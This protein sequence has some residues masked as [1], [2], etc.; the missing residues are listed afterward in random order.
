MGATLTTMSNTSFAESL[1]VSVTLTSNGA[2]TT[3]DGGNIK[4]LDLKLQLYA[5][6]GVVRIWVVAADDEDALYPIVCN[7]ELL[8]L[9]LQVAKALYDRSPTPAPLV[10]EAVVTQRHLREIPSPDLL[11]N[12]VLYREYELVFQDAA[13]ALWSQHHPCAVY[14]KTTL[15]SV[16]Q[17]NTPKDVRTQLVWSGLNKTRGIIC[18]GLGED[19]ASFYDWLFWVAD[20]ENG[21]I[22]YD[23]SEQRLVIDDQKPSLGDVDDLVPGTIA[24]TSTMKICLAPRQRAAITV[25]N[26]RDGATQRLDVTQPDAVAGVRRDFLVHTPVSAQ[27]KERQ[28]L[29]QR[30]AAGGRYDVQLDCHVYPELYLAPGVVIRVASE[31]SSKLL[32]SGE[33]LRVVALTLSAD[34]KNQVPEFDIESGTT[35]YACSFALQLEPEDDVRWRGPS[36]TPP[37]YPVEVEGKVLSAVGNAGDRSYTVYDDPNFYGAYR[38]NFPLWNSTVTIPVWP[39]FV[40]GH[41]YFPVPK[42]SRVF[43]SLQFDSARIARFLEWGKDVAVPNASQGNH[44]LLGRNAESETSIKHWY[45]DNVPQLVI[46]R[47][48]A[49]DR[50]TVTVDE[51]TLT[52]ELTEDGGGAGFGATVSVEPQAQLAKAKADQDSELAI[53]DM[54]QGAQASSERLGD[55]AR[56][57]ATTLKNQVRQA[58]ATI[59]TET[60]ALEAAIRGVGDDFDATVDEVE[61][62]ASATRQQLEDLF[63]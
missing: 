21:H 52:L 55:A 31:L 51:G 18:L 29:E 8:V 12:P 56:Q 13:Q 38:V 43:M 40:P 1:N 62:A 23:Y 32:V 15:S 61:T 9:R 27:A 42:D 22:W 59:E 11:A 14:A 60:D 63:K 45:V 5:A 7:D 26:S 41:L 37:R 47:V 4:Q 46:G 36:Y 34:A 48:N 54:Q 20:R 53:G 49:A 44:L 16:L 58:K 24:D 57:A 28:A 19:S 25:L 3:V 39:D 10:V 35:D 50:G 33:A 17:E 6:S 30:R 2:S